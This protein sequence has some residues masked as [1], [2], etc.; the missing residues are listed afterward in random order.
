MKEEGEAIMGKRR[1]RFRASVFTN[2]L[3]LCRLSMPPF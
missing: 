1:Q 3:P 2:N